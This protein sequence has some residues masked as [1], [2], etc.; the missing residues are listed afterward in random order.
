MQSLRNIGSKRVGNSIGVLSSHI[1]RH[2]GGS[3]NGMKKIIRL[4]VF[5]LA[6]LGAIKGISTPLYAQ[7]IEGLSLSLG[8]DANGYSPE[9]ADFGGRFSGDY[10]FSEMLSIGTSSLV[11][12]DDNMMTLEF[13]GN[14]RY[15]FF[16]DANS[17]TKH[18]NWA[19]VFHIFLQTEVGAAVFFTEGSS[20]QS[21]LMAGLAVG[22]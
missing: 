3:L 14:A 18:Y 5:I 4:S 9:T 15:Y 20:S 17:L 21:L 11:C 2:A 12:S 16:R 19:S 13:S 22:S 6:V 7:D 8:L 1:L 10:R